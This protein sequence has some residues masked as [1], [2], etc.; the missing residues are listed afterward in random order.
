MAW[1]LPGTTAR[2]GN[3]TIDAPHG[4]VDA[5]LGGVLQISLDGQP[6]H[7]SV[8]I[9]AGENID[10]SGSG[11]IGGSIS[12]TAGGNISGV[13]IGQQGVQINSRQNVAVTVFSGGNVDISASGAVSG[14]VVGAGTV[15]V[16]S[17]SITAAL[18][19]FSVATTGQTAGASIGIPQSNVARIDSRGEDDSATNTTQTIQRTLAA[20]DT[21]AA[22]SIPLTQKAGRVT[23]ILPHGT[24]PA[25]KSKL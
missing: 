14:T 5:S 24:Q 11:I 13:V 10:A 22:P 7:A 18:T 2:L 20:N 15:D 3:I 16:N 21:Q 6:S 9:D 23:V 25:T 19:G 1:T 12:L 8:V 4:S 17:D